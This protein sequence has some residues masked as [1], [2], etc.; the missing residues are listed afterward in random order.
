MKGYAGIAAGVVAVVAIVVA[1]L[2]FFTVSQTQQ[3]LVL[4]F[5]QPRAVI[6]QPGLHMKAPF[7]DSVV[8]LDKRVL[9]L[10][11]PEQEV[12]AQDKKRLV[13][14][15]FARWRITDP[16]RFYQ[17]LADPRIARMR[18][19][20]VLGAGVRQVLGDNT[21]AA[22]LSTKRAGLMH[23]IRDGVNA[24]TKGFGIN[25]IDVRIRRAD[26]PAANSA[27]IY[28][29]M[30]QE[31]VREANA[32]RA[33]GEQISREIR[34]KA[35]RQVTVILADA[36]RQAQITR[37]QGDAEST[38]IYAQAYGK[39]PNFYSF[40][41]SMDA[42]KGALKGNNTTVVLSPDSDFFRYFQ[43]GAAGR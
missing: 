42:Y 7:L 6:T 40:Y 30:Q 23:E 26:L 8:Y 32:F 2:T 4:R 41:R 29:R 9:N 22:V 20:P 15:A 12:I 33:Q 21:F 38:R 5:G 25:V 35:D 36:N 14:D 28:A 16:L 10:D 43:H 1:F 24:Q 18:L 31:R 11:L 3:A 19:Q 17:T 27:A 34:S 39:D 13:V 37:G